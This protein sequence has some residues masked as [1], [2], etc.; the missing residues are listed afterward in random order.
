MFTSATRCGAGTPYITFGNAIPGHVLH[1]PVLQTFTV[2]SEVR[3]RELCIEH[4]RCESYNYGS[5]NNQQPQ[6]CEVLDRDH[7]NYTHRE[8]DGFRFVAG[9][10]YHGRGTCE[11]L[12]VCGMKG[13]GGGGGGG[14]MGGGGNDQFG[15]CEMLFSTF[16]LAIFSK[17]S[18]DIIL[19][20]EAIIHSPPLA[21]PPPLPP[22]PLCT[23]LA[24]RLEADHLISGVEVERFS[25][26]H[27]S[28]R[29]FWATHGCTY[30]SLAVVRV[31]IGASMFP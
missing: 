22:R 25:Y 1:G 9:K 28:S 18:M 13:G 5:S 29:L 7:T 30:P 10:V 26:I 11:A 24:P 12:C 20:A 23:D 27:I 31:K 2:H 16:S 21:H 17:N 8:K 15:S 4:G 14:G 19:L 3:C 6:T